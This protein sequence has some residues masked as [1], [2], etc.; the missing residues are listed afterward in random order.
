MIPIRLQD[1]ISSAIND[2]EP[3]DLPKLQELSLAT[4]GLSI[5]YLQRFSLCPNLYR[6][7]LGDMADITIRELSV[8]IDQ[9]RV[10]QPHTFPAL[11]EICLSSDWLY[12]D[13]T[14]AERDSLEL[15]C[16]ENGITLVQEPEDSDDEDEDDDDEEY[17]SADL[18]DAEEEM[19]GW[20]DGDDF[21]DDEDGMS[22][23]EGDAGDDW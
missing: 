19:Y 22:G 13:D 21:D 18:E 2:L 15:I 23:D 14:E 3:Y 8:L 7:Q 10:A 9:S 11:K 6:V 1:S 5:S 4:D 12:G 20:G 16:F 17:D